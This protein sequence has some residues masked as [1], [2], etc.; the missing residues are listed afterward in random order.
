[1]YCKNCGSKLNENANVCTN[2]GVKVGNGNSFCKFCGNETNKDSKFCINCGNELNKPYIPKNTNNNKNIYCKNCSNE[3]NSQASV[4]TKCGVKR[5]NGNSYCPECGKETD[6]NA[7]VCVNC[8]VNLNN[9]F[10]VIN[11]INKSNSKVG[12]VGSKSKLLAIVLCLIFG[13]M[14]VHRFYVG[15]NSQG[16]IILALTL[17]GIVTCGITTIISCIWVIVD[18]IL[19]ILDKITDENGEALQW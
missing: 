2:C 13:T 10:S 16:F 4:C 17:A 12:S 3:M 19:I 6:K 11:S 18:F 14:G 5:G 15:D 9:K 8:G 7:D 1:M